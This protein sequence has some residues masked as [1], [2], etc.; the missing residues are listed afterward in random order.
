MAVKIIRNGKLD[1]SLLHRLEKKPGLYDPGD[2]IFWTDP[3]ISSHVLEAHLDPLSD[4][5]SR[6]AE[7]IEKTLRFISDRYPPETHPRLLDLG[8]GPGLYASQFH[9]AGYHVTGI[10]FSPVSIRYAKENA[11]KSRREITYLNIDYREWK[12]EEDSCEIIVMIFGDFCVLDPGSR[13]KLLANI[14]RALSPGGVFLFDVFT[15][16]YL[17]YPDERAWYTMLRDGFWHSGKNLVLEIK[18]RYPEKSVHLN[19]YLIITE[20]GTVRSCNLWHRWFERAE[21]REYLQQEGFTVEAM[22]ADLAGTP[23]KP[24]PE[25]IGIAAIPRV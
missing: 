23:L 21:I 5:A 1:L 22:W 8:C 18:H 19:R 17:P 2:F 16:M 9:D 4:D 6:R 25:W 24:S 13:K 3:Y 10:D 12:A 15:E 14:R 11:R 7:T 20:D